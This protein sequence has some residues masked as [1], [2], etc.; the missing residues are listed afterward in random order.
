[1]LRGP[2]NLYCPGLFQGLNPALQRDRYQDRDI[3]IVDSNSLYFFFQS[4]IFKYLRSAPVHEEIIHETVVT[5]EEESSN[6]GCGEITYNDGDDEP[7][8]NG[9]TTP[10]SSNIDDEELEIAEVIRKRIFGSKNKVKRL[11]L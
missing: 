5:D 8:D 6:S 3:R 2:L 11:N 10:K 1:M 4:S 7:Q 9:Q